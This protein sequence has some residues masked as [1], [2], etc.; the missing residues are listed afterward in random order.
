MSIYTGKGTQTPI[1]TTVQKEENLCYANSEDFF[2]DITLT[3][4][5]GPISYTNTS[6]TENLDFT[7]TPWSTTSPS[8][9]NVGKS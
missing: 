3:G 8:S 6:N 7:Y 1:Y 5:T 2:S 4:V 9:K